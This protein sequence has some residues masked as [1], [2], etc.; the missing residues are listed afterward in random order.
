MK[1]TAKQ[2]LFGLMIC[3]L[4]AGTTRAQDESSGS[5]RVSDQPSQLPS[6][7]PIFAGPSGPPSDFFPMMPVERWFAPRYYVDARGGT[8]YGY[9]ES[10]TNIG[11]F[12]PRFIDDDAMVYADARA[13]LGYDGRGGANLGLG[14][15]YYMP[16]YDRFIGFN[17]FYDFDASHRREYHQL[18]LGFESIGRYFDMIFNGYIPV[19]ERSNLLST[20][21][22]GPGNFAGNQILLDR[23]NETE[24]AFTGFD[25]QIGG[26]MPIFGRYGLQ[27]YVGFYFFTNSQVNKDFTGVSGRLAWQL[28]EDL[29]LAINMTDDSVFGF[30]SQIQVSM[31]LPDGKP[32]RWLRPLSVRDR[33]MNSAQRTYR[34]T[35]ER[36]ITVAAEAAINP[37]NNE[38]YFVVHVDPNVAGAGVAAG[39]GT[40]ENPFNLLS[41]FDNM[42]FGDKSNVDIIYV[43]AREDN[44]T[45]NLNQGVTLL[46]QQRLLSNRVPQFFET[47]QNPGQQYQLAGYDPIVNGERLL[48]RLSNESG[49]NVVTFADGAFCIEVSGFE[50]NGSATGRGI[51]GTNNSLVRINRNVIQGGQDGIY[52][53]GLSG[54]FADNRGSVIE[55]NIIR[56]NFND[57]IF[58]GNT[59]T[60]PLDLVIASNPPRNIDFDGVL[61]VDTNGDGEFDTG[62]PDSL[63]GDGSFAN[64]GIVSNGGDGIDINAD[65]GSVIN[66]FIDD[67]QIRGSQL[68]G[69]ALRATANSL[70]RGAI[71]NN[72]ITGS[73]EHGILLEAD[74]SELDLLNVV[75]GLFVGR[76]AGNEIRDNVG[77]GIHIDAVQS[78]IG[79]DIHTNR[80]GVN[81][82][83]ITEAG[84]LVGGNG[85]WDINL[86][87]QGGS[88]LVAIGGPTADFGNL[89]VDSGVGA[90]R[91]NLTGNNLTTTQ[92]EHNR[93][94]A[95]VAGDQGDVVRAG[96]S[97]FT[98]APN[99]DLSTGLVPIGFD[100]DF[101]GLDFNQVYVN[102]NGNITFLN[103]LGAFTPFPIVQNGIPMIAPFF[104]DV[105]TRNH[106]EPVTY[107]TGTVNGLNAF[108][109]NWVDVDYFI[110]NTAHDTQLNSFQLV[111]IDRSDIAPGDFDIEFNYDRIVWETGDA[112]GGVNGLGGNSARA[113]FT[114]G[115]TNSFEFPGSA[116]NGALLDSGPAATSLVQNSFNSPLNGRYVFKARNGTILEPGGGSG[117]PPGESA[118]A[119]LLNVNEFAQLTNSIVRNNEI[120]GQT[121]VDGNQFGLS[122]NTRNVGQVTNMLVDNNTINRND[123][124]IQFT[125]DQ[126]S[127]LQAMMMNNTV[128]ENLG[129]GIELSAD[130]TGIGGLFITSQDND[131][132]RNQGDGL[133]IFAGGSANVTFESTRD[134]FVANVGNNIALRTVENSNVL[135]T[136]DDVAANGSINGSGFSGDVGGTSS[137]LIGIGSPE[138]VPST[139]SNNAVHGFGLTAQENGFATVGIADS[140]FSGNGAD[141]INFNRLDASLILAFID[142]TTVSGNGD[143]GIQFNTA[144]AGVFDATT[145]LYDGVR[146]PTNRLVLNNV[147]VTGQRNANAPNGANGLEIATQGQ[148]FLVV[149]AFNSSF[150]N[151]AGDG[152][153]IFAGQGSSFGD[154]LTGERSTFSG[155]TMNNNDLDG[156]RVFVQGMVAS[157]PTAL[158]DINSDFGNTRIT[159]NGDDGIEASVIYGD[160]DLLVRG[161][162]IGL[163]N[164]NTFIQRNGRVSGANGHG[165]EFNVG[166]GAIDGDT[167]TGA[168]SIAHFYFP[169]VPGSGEDSFQIFQQP[170]DDVLATG[171]L[172][173][174]DSIIGDENL[175]D[176]TNNGNAGDGIHVHG[177][178]LSNYVSRFLNGSP[179]GGAVTTTSVFVP[180]SLAIVNIDN[181]VI[182]G[183]GQN[184][185]HFVGDSGRSPT[186]NPYTINAPAG[187]FQPRFALETAQFVSSITNNTI[188]RNARDGISIELTGK[189]GDW[190]AFGGQINRFDGNSFLIE[191]NTIHR[192]ARHGVFFESNAGNQQFARVFFIDPGTPPVPF[193]PAAVGGVAGDI[194]NADGT[195][196]AGAFLNLT[197][198]AITDMQMYNNDI[199]F[200]GTAASNVGEG[201]YVRVSTNSYLGLDMGGAVGSGQGNVFS[202]NA[203]SDVRFE[204]FVAFNP[205]TG[206][207][208]VPQAS[209]VTAGDTGVDQISLDH[210]AQMDL[211]FNNNTGSLMASN[212]SVAFSQ[213][214][215]AFYNTL[216][217]AKSGST[218]RA[219]Q[220]FQLDGGIFAN[221]NNPNWGA[222]D[223]PS[224]FSGAGNFHLRTINDPA[225]AN[226]AFPRPWVTA[227]GQIFLP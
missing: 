160:L 175:N 191:N 183:N 187:S 88:A 172:T 173:V 28:N 194:F 9:E 68:N 156:M 122:V 86:N 12:M 40:V 150:S 94:L 8:L 53:T 43:R 224:A 142:D 200:N 186:T 143:D 22:Q 180:Q 113:G 146:A 138:G 5:A 131:V 153:R 95:G 109:V 45:T 125:R 206:V 126:S 135:L 98:L 114:N 51:Y 127:L 117:G 188:N 4:I 52:L 42:V 82:F 123:G 121:N 60:A 119:I 205:V 87:A 80:F 69:I 44:T 178:I 57:G 79:L 71:I 3:A 54:Q 197:S 17:A 29:N 61:D 132:E 20:S 58:V 24:S 13:L 165:I 91:F 46:S 10:F 210:T 110:S 15:R 56:N 198:A 201:V 212:F 112:S 155:V 192:N 207:F 116:V 147:T 48:P 152:A 225:F 23:Y 219:L 108:G 78:T 73:Q 70:I 168:N 14:W 151:N 181:N 103:P 134:R 75:P 27:G 136:L 89:F 35:V 81:T 140:V 128:N 59:G 111:L 76:I 166:D 16:D 208:E 144:G 169:F 204:S 211:R 104:A 18:G 170:G 102:N 161:D 31:N 190:D 163:P 97:Q 179:N 33:M 107:G 162:E 222:Q 39:D 182:S 199:R 67:N 2:C 167:T 164:F 154:R 64:D 174:R 74:N 37:K 1:R 34:V 7:S 85:G 62:S 38:P 218:F 118:G 93:I 149:N 171:V 215:S 184:G 92:I 189:Y 157:T 63:D 72:S 217:T 101:F 148:S 133:N 25:A 223:L 129:N 47:A 106:G 145:P 30:N 49:G 177:S 50:I 213:N 227:P 141:G 209:T 90:V 124:G 139:F 65:N 66:V 11:A 6:E 220:L 216:D 36:D 221:A 100:A 99:D 130:G 96:F 105:D 77:D 83:N 115:T 32:S 195:F 137:V 202:G 120:L 41:Q 84:T 185:I 159:N 158:I 203:L 193:S 196:R 19:G 214:Q 21:L 176:S 55:N 226:P 26:P